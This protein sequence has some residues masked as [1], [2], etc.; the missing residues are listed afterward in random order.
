MMSGPVV[1]VPPG[2]RRRRL[3]LISLLSMKVLVVTQ[4]DSLQLPQDVQDIGLCFK[5]DV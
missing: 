1:A 5:R 3:V 4:V 2:H